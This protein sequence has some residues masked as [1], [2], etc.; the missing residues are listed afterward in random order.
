LKKGLGLKVTLARDLTYSGLYW[1]MVEQVRNLIAG[2]EYREQ[3]HSQRSVYVNVIP[4]MIGGSLISILTTPFDTI[5]T[6]IQSG[7]EMR[8][9]LT[10]QIRQ[11]FRKE[12]YLG[13][14]SGVQHRVA[15]NTITS[16]LYLSIF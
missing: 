11:T 8:G 7:V 14:F 9:T 13:L 4:P 10:E 16:V 15:R 3:R 1:F 2:A 6:R 5:K 12:G